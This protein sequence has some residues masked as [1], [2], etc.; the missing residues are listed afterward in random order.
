MSLFSDLYAVP[1]SRS[2]V[3]RC[4]GWSWRSRTQGSLWSVRGWLQHCLCHQALPHQ[5]SHCSCTGEAALVIHLLCEWKKPFVT[6]PCFTGWDQC[7]SGEHGGWWLEVAFLWHGEGIWL[8]GRPGCY[9]LHDRAGSASC[10]G[11]KVLYVT[12]KFYCN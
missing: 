1:S 11:G 8:A 7:C 10:S 5:V 4:R 12:D 3:W 9:P 2:W 6:L